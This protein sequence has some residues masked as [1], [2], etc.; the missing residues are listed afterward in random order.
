MAVQAAEL[1]L[2]LALDLQFFRQQ[3]QKAQAIAAAEFNPA[4]NIRFNETSVR[5]ELKSLQTKIGKTTFRINVQSN[6]ESQAK[7][8]ERIAAVAPALQR[9]AAA[10]K[11]LG[12]GAGKA[13]ED[14]LKGL[15]LRAKALEK[16][17]GKTGP[18][19]SS[20]AAIKALYEKG[21]KEIGLQGGLKTR[22]EQAAELARAFSQMSKDAVNGFVQ[23]FNKEALK[24]KE[25]GA[26]L[27]KGT[28]EGLA[29]SLE[30]ASPSKRMKELGKDASEGFVIGL[31]EGLDDIEQYARRVKA[32]LDGVAKEIATT[33]KTVANIQGKRL[34]LSNLPLM[35]RSL[36]GKGERSS[37]AIGG[38]GAPELLQAIYPEVKRTVS[39]LSLLRDQVNR[40]SSKLSGF[41]LII[42]LAA[43]AGVPLAKN[44][45]KLTESA[46]DFAKLL[47]RLGVKLEDAVIKAASDILRGAA[48]KFLGGISPAGLLPPAYRGI[49]PAAGPAGLLGAGA[50]PAGLLPPA[51]RGIGPGAVAGA[52]PPAYRGLPFG[53]DFGALPPSRGGEQD[54]GPLVSLETG[55]IAQMRERYA[56]VAKRFLFGVET[57][58][59]DLFDSVQ[60][61]VNSAVDQ[62]I[63]KIQA[64]LQADARRNVNVRDLGNVIQ[65]ALP[66]GTGRTP[67]MLPP[68][69]GSSY[70]YGGG[71]VPPGGFPVDQAQWPSRPV[72]EAGRNAMQD[73]GQRMKQ[74]QQP[75]ILDIEIP[76]TGAIKELRQ[77]LGF[78][79]KQLV[80][81]GTAYKALAFFQ[82]F[83]RSVVESVAALQSYRNSL[84]AVTGSAEAFAIN[85]EYILGLVE[86]YNIPLETARQGF[87]KLYASMAPSGF[88][89]TEIRDLFAA[90]TKGAATFGMSADQVDRVIYAF[91]QMA[92][93]GQVMSEE[94]KGQLG[95]VLPG[96]VAIF[97]EAAGF[98][99]PAA[100]AQFNKAL[101]E[102]T[103]KGSKMR[104]LLLNVRKVMEQEFGPGAEGAART[105]QGALNR[106]NNSVKLLYEAFEPFAIQFLNGV[107]T[108]VTN[109]LKTVTE[110]FKQFFSG[111]AAPSTGGQEFAGQLERL[112]PAFEGIAAN[113]RSVL[114]QIQLLGSGFLELAKVFLQIVGSPV[115]GF[116]LRLYATILPLQLALNV[117]RLNALIPLIGSFAQLVGSIPLLFRNFGVL[118]GAVS[119]VSAAV[120]SGTPRFAAIRAALIATGLSGQQAAAGFR[121]A[122]VGVGILSA[123]LS[124]GLLIAVGLIIQRFAEMKAGLDGIASAAKSAGSA[125][126]SMARAGDVEGV[127]QQAKDLR[128][129]IETYRQLRAIA[130]GGIVAKQLTNQQTQKIQEI[131]LG[132]FIGKDI[133]SGNYAITDIVNYKEQLDQAIQKYTAEFLKTGDKFRQAQQVKLQRDRQAAADAARS[134]AASDVLP[135]AKS[136]A[137]TATTYDAG[138][139]GGLAKDQVQ[140]LRDL[141]EGSFN[142]IMT[143]LEL[144]FGRGAGVFQPFVDFYT[145][146]QQFNKKI[147]EGPLEIMQLQAKN[148]QQEINA[149]NTEARNAARVANL[150]KGTSFAGFSV[151]DVPGSPRTY[152]NG[153]HEGHDIATPIGTAL[154]YAI[155]GVVKSIDRVGRGYGG[156]TLEVQL[157]NG[158]TGFSAHLSDVLVQVGQRF[159]AGQIL[160]RTGNTGTGTG[161]HLHQESAP[162]G[163][164][165]GQAGASLSYLQLNGRTGTGAAGFTAAG[166]PP[167]GR[168]A[169]SAATVAAV[170]QEELI[171][172][173]KAIAS[174]LKKD[175]AELY[176]ALL[177]LNDLDITSAVNQ[178]LF[179]LNETIKRV[180]R[181]TQDLWDELLP[182]GAIS[183]VIKRGRALE[184]AI[185]DVPTKFRD[186]QKQIAESLRGQEITKLI[187]SE[188]FLTSAP[189]K[190]LQKQLID[191][192][193]PV[194]AVAKAF[195]AGARSGASLADVIAR[196]QALL[197]GLQAEQLK[198][199]QIQQ[200]IN[201][202]FDTAVGI[203]K[204]QA[205]AL[206]A[207]G[208]PTKTQ[209]NAMQRLE[210]ERALVLAQE[211]LS[212]A[213][214]QGKTEEIALQEKVIEGLKMQK[215]AMTEILP[216][217]A[218][219][220]ETMQLAFQPA[221]DAF[222]D[223]VMGTKTAGEAFR[224]FAYD[225]VSGLAKMAAQAATMMIFKQI[226]G[227]LGGLF[228]FNAGSLFANGGVATGG[229]QAFANGGIAPGG[230]K[231]RAFAGGG[232]VS[233]PTMGL[234]GEGRYNEAIVPLPDGKSIPVVMRGAG[235]GGGDNI[236]VNVSVDATG[237]K[238]QGDSGKANQLG[239]ALS[240]AIQAE[241]L[242][243]KRPG[244]ILA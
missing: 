19:G 199:L 119:S 235:D 90:I 31:N 153:V 107:V 201:Q 63:L 165:T 58:V 209:D 86:K 211:S 210:I 170:S 166:A 222:T 9:A 180:K 236:N 59:V 184:R 191:I 133:I 219:L 120:A 121:A 218:T 93:K 85:N 112:R 67:L 178:Q 52:L 225:V 144:K 5:R 140:I 14:A 220:G 194:D 83:P 61:A 189:V 88:S 18:T 174:S 95:D 148:M 73:I 32:I 45:V 238:V 243:Q 206:S 99:G 16:T 196:L 131:G 232:T 2:N 72:R 79:I 157:E 127:R 25:A 12:K 81:F 125:M 69:G 6:L 22:K 164:R 160:A 213:T 205:G 108:P 109:G 190:E 91:S 35:T 8:A 126:S 87:V 84:Q 110:G 138:A 155:G 231:F 28:L 159:S 134:A 74:F 183:D 55:F 30:I 226:M 57:E 188:A 142:D 203:Q 229:F 122:A 154:S 70:R 139:F 228:G 102:G 145:K 117:L 92:S 147:A 186:I 195:E 175:A 156:K 237:S 212:R 233:G 44:I 24:G 103:Y 137:I 96:A 207:F 192:G 111:I 168:I 46:G 64:R 216:G 53:F 152:R 29:K 193:A 221:V 173:Q 51:Y 3:L 89:G 71:Y 132:R 217:V 17:L 76:G 214:V 167:G 116:F 215:F 187:G 149:T 114:P 151:T 176:N 23:G 62:Y 185:E 150:R 181:E 198:V 94:L 202:K 1:R 208:L 11:Q 82:N 128:A 39:A 115:A 40:N 48:G 80:L 36:E 34:G 171:A 47:D 204:A 101:E 169:P 146:L 49:G 60:Q 179:D 224:Q 104:E 105:F 7:Y 4:L 227:G 26:R 41:S 100:I 182:E 158:I 78:A 15:D 20:A 66:G 54:P 130:E 65:N 124:A 197:P 240:S 21:V 77:E 37:A 123:A 143:Q 177:E 75:K 234:V 38:A 239:G 161:P 141:L 129:Q 50:G 230:I 135:P 162:Y 97:A 113:V 13:T 106:M 223:F 200:Q 244:G 163:Y 56:R 27:G 172:K 242:K 98:K 42:G 43:F 136:K 33:G 118:N 241:L 68:A 10:F